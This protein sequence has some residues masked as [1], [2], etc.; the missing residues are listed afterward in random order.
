MR[1]YYEDPE[2]GEKTWVDIEPKKK[3]SELPPH[4]C[5]EFTDRQETP[6]P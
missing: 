6:D 2:T 5:L 4:C 3:S 1:A